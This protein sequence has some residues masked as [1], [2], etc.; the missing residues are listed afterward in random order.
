MGKILI[1]CEF[2]RGKVA[3]GSE[4]YLCNFHCSYVETMMGC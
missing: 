2:S 3:D 4:S 1:Y